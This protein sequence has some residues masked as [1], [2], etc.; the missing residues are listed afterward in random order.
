MST[1]SND[2]KKLT[3]INNLGLKKVLNPYANADPRENLPASERNRISDMFSLINP[4]RN[5]V[6]VRN[7]DSELDEQELFEIE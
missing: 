6:K 4:K 3:V 1:D 5:I 2:I 7:D